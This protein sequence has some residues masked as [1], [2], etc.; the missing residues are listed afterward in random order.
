MY[1]DSKMLLLF[2]C[3][4]KC[5]SSFGILKIDAGRCTTRTGT[6]CE[7]KNQVSSEVKRRSF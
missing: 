6:A 4:P 7:Y 5:E 1:Y 2:N 3:R